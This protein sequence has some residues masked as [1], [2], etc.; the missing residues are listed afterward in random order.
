MSYESPIDIPPN[1]LG[2]FS[3]DMARHEIATRCQIVEA[4][5]QLDECIKTATVEL[6]NLLRVESGMLSNSNI[7]KRVNAAIAHGRSVHDAVPESHLH[8]FDAGQEMQRLRKRIADVQSF[9]DDHLLPMIEQERRMGDDSGM[10]SGIEDVCDDSDAFAGAFTDSDV[11][12]RKYDD[13]ATKS[14]GVRVLS[15]DE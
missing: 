11:E 10:S 15:D 12:M 4:C 1:L 14:R 8:T 3:D 9:L 13:P 2:M 5:R 7:V 6:D